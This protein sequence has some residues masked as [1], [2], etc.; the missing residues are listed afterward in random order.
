MLIGDRTVEPIAGRAK[1]RSESGL[2]GES[3][4]LCWIRNMGNIHRQI[5]NG[6]ADAYDGR[7]ILGAETKGAVGTVLRGSVVA[8]SFAMSLSDEE[9]MP[10]RKP[11]CGQ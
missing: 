4:E 3:R 1:S 2:G 10:S 8:V 11:F 7:E 6:F 9:R 5:C